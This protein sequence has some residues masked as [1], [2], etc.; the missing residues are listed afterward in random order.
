MDSGI[1]VVC[2]GGTVA[3]TRACSSGCLDNPAPVIDACIQTLDCG[4][5]VLQVG[6]ACD[7]EPCCVDCAV[8]PEATL[9]DSNAEVEYGCPWGSSP[10]EAV[11][12]R[13]RARLCTGLDTACDGNYGDWSSWQPFEACSIHES[14]D[15]IEFTCTCNASGAWEPS[16]TS[17]TDDKGT[18]YEEGK[19]VSIDTEIRLEITPSEVFGHLRVRACKL[20]DPNNLVIGNDVYVHIEDREN[21][22]LF[23]GVLY[24][25]G[26]PCTDGAE[27]LGE[28]TYVEGDVLLGSWRLSSPSYIA[29]EWSNACTSRLSGPPGS[30]WHG[31][32]DVGLERTCAGH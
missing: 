13:S 10:G 24:R 4:D 7:G 22:V 17:G 11:G 9:C 8:A 32:L 15:P 25:N 2:D 12:A 23:D 1:L 28:E 31:E 5:G 29:R 21:K 30:C 14:C 20:A 3:E 18:Q 19:V 27:I 26:T 16:E 6:E